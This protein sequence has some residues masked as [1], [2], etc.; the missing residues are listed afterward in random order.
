M[1]CPGWQDGGAVVLC[2]IIIHGD[3]IDFNKHLDKI[4]GN[5]MLKKEMGFN[6]IIIP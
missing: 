6:W 5:P 3:L 4:T 1:K 2:K